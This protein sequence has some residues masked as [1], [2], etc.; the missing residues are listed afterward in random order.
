MKKRLLSVRWL[1]W[2]GLVTHV[3]GQQQAVSGTVPDPA[4]GIP[5]S[6]ATASMASTQTAVATDNNGNY[7]FSVPSDAVL[8]FR[9]GG[10]TAQDIPINGRQVV[11]MALQPSNNA[12]EEVMVVAYG[13]T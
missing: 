12:L 1:L 8:T 5:L 3:S 2:C 10:Y 13:T 9:A 11:N 4:T 6:G 7:R